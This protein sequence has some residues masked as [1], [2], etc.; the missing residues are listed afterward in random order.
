[1][2]KLNASKEE[3]VYIGDS[4]VDIEAAKNAGLPCISVAWGFK[5]R[6][7]LEE[8]DAEMIVD[9]PEEILELV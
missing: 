8:H 2:K 5:G 3:S 1:M 4:E 7:F 9:A 6:D